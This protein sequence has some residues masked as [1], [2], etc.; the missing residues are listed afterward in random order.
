MTVTI[1]GTT[2]ID[3]VQDGSITPIKLS[4]PFTS[5]TV[6]SASG[7]SVD[8]TGIPSWV[9]QINILFS[10]IST[11]GT[12]I[13]LV[14][15]GDIDGVETTSYA[16]TGASIPN[17]SSPTTSTSTAGFVIQS[18]LAANVINGCVSLHLLSSSSNTWVA[19]VNCSLSSSAVCIQGA[20]VKAL[21]TTLDRVRITT[22]NGTDAFDGG[23]F[24]I[25]YEG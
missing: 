23:Q 7:T 18:V 4:Q 13:P 19:S 6:V 17:G 22:T 3:N 11:N 2:G 1:N 14:Q 10:S 16:S 9:K 15:I 12:S 8:F 21:S 5:G 24:N 20:G 25:L